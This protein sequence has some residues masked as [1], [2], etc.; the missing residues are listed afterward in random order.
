M[1][2]SVT[3]RPIS[4]RNLRRIFT[5]MMNNGW[6]RAVGAVVITAVLGIWL[7]NFDL[8]AEITRQIDY[9][10]TDYYDR[11]AYRNTDLPYDDRVLIV[12]TDR[13]DTRDE[14]AVALQ[15]ISAHRPAAIGLDLIFVHPSGED[16]MLVGTMRTT[17]DLVLPV[18]LQFA[19]REAETFYAA[20]E[21]CFADS[22]RD[23]QR[24][25]VN[26][27]HIDHYGIERYYR[28][29]YDMEDGTRM[30]GMALALA[31]KLSPEAAAR[32]AAGDKPEARINFTVARH[33][34]LDAAELEEMEPEDL[35]WHIRGKIVLVG[36]IENKNDIH[37]TIMAEDTP[38]IML[39]AIATSTILSGK[40]IV[41][42]PRWTAWIVTVLFTALV[43]LIYACGAFGRFT[44]FW[45]L[46]VKTLL[47]LVVLLGGYWLYRC[48]GVAVEFTLTVAVVFFAMTVCE[49][50][51]NF[52]DAFKNEDKL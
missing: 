39:H 21:S 16:S 28:K 31:E 50:W 2:T 9:N 25:G 18:D 12:G 1:Q 36:D 45:V 4:G 27:I 38:G 41:E 11:R 33:T 35:D 26:F 7:L 20:M 43:I 30:P 52:C 32:A 48:A 42:A 19:D 13:L 8:F 22:L 44:P 37:N 40:S 10:S 24:A 29:W 49:L 3:K 14:I 46:L 6:F 34:V 15:T 23:R 5:A 47:I 17:P 51:Y